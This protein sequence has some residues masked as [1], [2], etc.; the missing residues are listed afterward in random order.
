MNVVSNDDIL[1]RTYEDEVDATLYAEGARDGLSLLAD[2]AIS[3][4]TAA[5]LAKV[6]LQ[7]RQ[8]VEAGFT[9]GL[10][11]YN[12]IRLPKLLAAPA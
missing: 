2:G 6:K 8:K 11:A 7:G 4:A 12:L 1:N 9:L 5:E 3:L 10:L